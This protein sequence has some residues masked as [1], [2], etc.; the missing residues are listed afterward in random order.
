MSKEGMKA[1]KMIAQNLGVG[2]VR[3]GEFRLILLAMGSFKE[4]R[5]VFCFT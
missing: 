2:R 5:D 1:A 3:E 4:R